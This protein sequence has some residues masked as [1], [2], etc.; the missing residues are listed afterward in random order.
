MK[1]GRGKGEG[2]SKDWYA[3]TLMVAPLRRGGRG[4]GRDKGSKP[5][6]FTFC[7]F[8]VTSVHYIPI[9]FKDSNT[10][11]LAQLDSTHHI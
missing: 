6:F 8:S 4:K 7:R 9:I 10:A 11:L 3:L 1:M 2:G 5:H